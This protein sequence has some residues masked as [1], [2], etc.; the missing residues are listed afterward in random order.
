MPDEMNV[1]IENL[2]AHASRV[3]GV[4]DG[5]NVAVDASQE[6][7]LSSEAYGILC[8]PFA[9]MLLPVQAYGVQALQKAVEAVT[10]T[11]ENVRTTASNYESV[12]NENA[13]QIGG[14]QI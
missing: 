13:G 9:L 14:I 2:R 12:D 11:A 7:T 5:L 10:D 6:V 8:Q 4:V 1:V 3:D